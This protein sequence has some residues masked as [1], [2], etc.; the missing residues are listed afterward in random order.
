MNDL[1]EN[2]KIKDVKDLQNIIIN[3]G[4][5]LD[6]NLVSVSNNGIEF[7]Y[8]VHLTNFYTIIDWTDDGF[9]NL[10]SNYQRKSIKFDLGGYLKSNNEK[11]KISILRE[12]SR[13]MKNIEA[14]DNSTDVV[15]TKENEIDKKINVYSDQII[16]KNKSQNKKLLQVLL[17]G[18]LILF[19]FIIHKNYI[20][21]NL[22]GCTENN[23]RELQGSLMLTREQA[24]QTCC[25]YNEIAKEANEKLHNK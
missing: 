16:Q 10:S 12:V 25:E 14:E 17:I 6:W 9:V 7:N 18:A 15:N 2:F 23:I 8:Q 13:H 3:S 5:E 20:A 21:E 1:K 19:G 22:C 24:I 11:I 4:K